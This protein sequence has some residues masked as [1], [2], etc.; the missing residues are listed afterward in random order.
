MSF[1]VSFIVYEFI[2]AVGIDDPVGTISLHGTAGIIGLIL[3]PILNTDASFYGQ[4]IGTRAMVVKSCD[5]DSDSVYF[6]VPER[7]VR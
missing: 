4:L 2:R 1:T 7:K 5:S 6:G 3:V